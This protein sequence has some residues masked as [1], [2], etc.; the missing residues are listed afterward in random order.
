MGKT[1]FYETINIDLR[2]IGYSVL[3][4]MKDGDEKPFGT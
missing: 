1:T 4:E 3:R 2:H